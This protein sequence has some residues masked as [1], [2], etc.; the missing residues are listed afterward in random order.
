MQHCLSKAKCQYGGALCKNLPSVFWQLT[1]LVV[2]A[3]NDKTLK[4]EL[5]SCLCVDNLWLEHDKIQLIWNPKQQN[6]KYSEDA[7]VSQLIRLLFLV[8]YGREKDEERLI[9]LKQTECTNILH[10]MMTNKMTLIEI[11]HEC[12]VISDMSP[13]KRIN[14][15]IRSHRFS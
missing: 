3:S 11:A 10:R 1:S 7:A 14:T 13:K 4:H 8:N 5:I 6:S 12:K 15:G 2:N 9:G